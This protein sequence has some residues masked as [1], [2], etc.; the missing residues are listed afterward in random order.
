MTSKQLIK[1][2]KLLTLVSFLG[3]T[4]IFIWFWFTMSSNAL[5]LGYG[6]IALTVIGNIGLLVVM[7][8]RSLHD[9]EN[10]SRLLSAGARMFLNIPLMFVYIGLANMLLNRVR[11]TFVNTTPN[12]LTEIRLHGCEELELSN[13]ASGDSKN[14][15]IYIPHDCSVEMEYKI[16]GKKKEVPIW[17]YASPDLEQILTYEIKS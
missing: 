9:D 15:W 4:L 6:Y 1:A 11:V 2:A 8:V 12:E 17:G 5:F 16:N 10:R 13:I 14:V 3:G 7:L